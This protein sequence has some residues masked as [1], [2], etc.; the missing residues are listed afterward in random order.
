[1]KVL[2]SIFTITALFL[3]FAGGCTECYN[4]LSGY[5]DLRPKGKDEYAS[6]KMGHTLV[7]K[8]DILKIKAKGE[9]IVSAD[10]GFS[11]VMILSLKAALN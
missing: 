8:H 7:W 11:I 10:T 1:M 2:N 4:P 3:T 9:R 5:V 6:F